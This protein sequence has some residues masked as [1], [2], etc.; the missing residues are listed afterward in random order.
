MNLLTFGCGFYVM[1]Q[2]WGDCDS[3]DSKDKGNNLRK[4]TKIKASIKNQ[5]CD[6]LVIIQKASAAKLWC[7]E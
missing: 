2:V 3:G 7:E 6:H 4:R 5:S 1:G